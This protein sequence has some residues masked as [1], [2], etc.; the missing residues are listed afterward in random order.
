MC[1]ACIILN[2]SRKQNN[3][4]YWVSKIATWK[5]AAGRSSHPLTDNI[6]T[7]YGFSTCE[8]YCV[9][10]MI[11]LSKNRGPPKISLLQ[12]LQHC[13]PLRVLIRSQQAESL[14]LTAIPVVTMKPNAV[15]LYLALI[16]RLLV[17]YIYIYIYIPRVYIIFL[18]S[19]QALWKF[20]KHAV[21]E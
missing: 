14:P 7:L 12:G 19:Q 9:S 15:C 13:L 8:L 5:A 20:I 10:S 2:S 6:C 4:Y 18:R 21:I 17:V 3:A 16:I 11:A 1:I